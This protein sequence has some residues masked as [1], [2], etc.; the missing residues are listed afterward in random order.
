MIVDPSIMIPQ[1]PLPIAIA[2]GFDVVLCNTIATASCA[3]SIAG[4]VPTILYV[5]EV[6]LL[7]ER[8]A[9]SPETNASLAKVAEVWAGSEL[10]AG[11]LRP[12][13][14]D[15]LVMPYG[16]DPIRD[17]NGDL[18]PIGPGDPSI[19]VVLASFEPRKGQDLLVE[20][21]ALLDPAVRASIRIRM[22]GRILFPDFHAALAARVAQIPE[23]SLHGPLDA[24]A[25]RAA[26]LASDAVL[27]PSRSDTL[28]LVSLDALGAG[29]VLFCTTSTGTAAY[30]ESG[31]SGFVAKGPTAIDLAAMLDTALARRAEWPSIA[32]T[33][34]AV[35]T[36]HFSQEAFAALVGK[37]FDALTA[38]LG[39]RA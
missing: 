31:K 13:R 19:L 25:Y 20:A 4:E 35:F 39:N 10:S 37:R 30:I 22:Y 38:D 28:P 9:E 27:V 32:I 24:D 11:L 26:V 18:P 21:F 1:A 36:R 2:K 8:M 6:S 33:G 34:Q 23:I 3:A 16:L 15:V 12:V 29:R 7:E 17:A 14:P 5:H